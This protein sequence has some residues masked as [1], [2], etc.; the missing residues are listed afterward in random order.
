MP[1]Y[2]LSGQSLEFPATL[3]RLESVREPFGN[4][5][6]SLGLPREEAGL[7]EVVASEALTNAVRH[8]SNSD[9]TRNVRVDWGARG[10]WIFFVVEDSGGGP[11]P[12]Q[13][14]SSLPADPLA[15]GGRGLFL[16]H[17]FCDTVEEW[18][19]ASGYRLVLKKR[20]SVDAGIPMAPDLRQ[21]LDEITLCYESLSA[22]YKLGSTLLT[23]RSIPLFVSDALAALGRLLQAEVVAFDFEDALEPA[24]LRELRALP[25]R[26]PLP[27]PSRV[28]RQAL[29]HEEL[30]LW[31]E[32]ADVRS[33]ENL[34][35][36]PM[37]CC[38]P[39]G[40]AGGRLGA[41]LVARAA[42][43]PSF[44]TG[45]TQAIRTFA[46]VIGMAVAHANS[47]I[48]RAREAEALNEV[49]LAAQLQ[50]DL[51]PPTSLPKSPRWALSVHRSSANEVAGDVALAQAV[52]GSILVTVADVVG[53]GVPAAFLAAMF[54]TAFYNAVE[55]CRSLETIMAVINRNFHRDV[56]QLSLF[57]TCVIVRLPQ[58][59]S[60]LEIVNAGHVPV[61]LMG[62]DRILQEVQ[63]MA[64]PVGLFMGES[65]RVER[66]RFDENLDSLMIVTDGVYEWLHGQ[67]TWGWDR[68]RAFSREH[69][70]LE[71]DTFW[72]DM[73]NL[74]E[75]RSSAGAGSDDRT[76]F[77]CRN[78]EAS[79]P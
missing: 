75:R 50:R 41:L 23:A 32:P 79:T 60:M 1:L 73:E 62:K 5:L 70:P 21:A 44:R 47:Q 34:S 58:D 9:P 15:V 52:D 56:G 43:S 72:S 25:E 37:G 11:A 30:Y 13:T 8:G 19:G 42:G 49:R 53:K 35:R 64:P 78:L 54:R 45:E 71:P 26:F 33:E 31:E 6:R 29:Q 18:R 36:F 61:L 66:I 14:G 69:L 74:I 12:D 76:M 51:L 55:N 27:G 48:V 59:G 65:F 28:L 38:C 67:E 16:I 4:F 57:A 2:P 20:L 46:D 40:A 68:F 77:V 24:L 22:F 10:A 63:A 17:Q 3:D 39:V 7:W